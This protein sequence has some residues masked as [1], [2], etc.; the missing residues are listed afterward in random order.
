[1]PRQRLQPGEHGRISEWTSSGRHFAATY[2]RDSDGKRRRVERSSRKSTEDARR[3]LQRHLQG[4]RAPMSG[5]IVTDR[6][7]LA[8]LFAIWIE[9]K[10]V[11]DGVSQ[12][13]VNQYRAVWDSHGAEQL[14]ALR[15]G[16]LSTSR[17]NAR[18][19][20]MGATT[21]AKRLRMILSG[22][23]G[24]AVRYD[25]L[26]VNPIREARTVK[27]TRKAAKAATAAEFERVRAAVRAYVQREGS[28][29]Q[30][31]RLLPAFVELLAAT[32]ARP[33]EVLAMRWSDV[34]LLGNPPTAIITGTLIDH[35]RIAG[36]PLHR[37]D[38]RKG[39]AAPHT[40]VLPRFGVEALASLV[41]ESGMDGPVFANRDGDWM[42]LANMR[43]SLRAALPADLSW[44]TPHSFRRTVA[45]VV[46]DA[47]GAEVAQQ[48]LSHAKLATTEAH[49]LQ[50]HT[51]GPDVRAIL[52]EFAGQESAERK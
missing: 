52:D 18:L 34:D 48:Q 46:R 9:A 45:T 43:R 44:V 19:Q 15:T 4:R 30:R 25:V 32:G 1:M 6:T 10:A 38:N 5:Q 20:S 40:V 17:A 33:N 8:E 12:Q 2:V 35:G 3:V 31:G 28:G 27:T 14:G 13:T 39:D 47:L 29:P 11:V 50:R 16:E 37:Q 21:Q 41:S 26:A 7:T 23:Y 36:K 42:S 24:L 22:M 49:Y 51:R